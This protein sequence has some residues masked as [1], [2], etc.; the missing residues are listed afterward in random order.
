[1]IQRAMSS[2]T[3]HGEKKED[4]KITDQ[5]FLH[6]RGSRGNIL[7]ASLMSRNRRQNSGNSIAN[8]ISK[9]FHM[10]ELSAK[11]VLD[12]GC[13]KSGNLELMKRRNHTWH[14]V[15]CILDH[16]AHLYIFESEQSSHSIQICPLEHATINDCCEVNLSNPLCVELVFAPDD[17]KKMPECTLK[18]ADLKDKHDWI[19]VLRN[20]QGHI[21]HGMQSP[22]S[23]GDALSPK[24]KDVDATSPAAATTSH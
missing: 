9:M 11:E 10:Q 22:T 4:H 6:K 16:D 2:G 12:K 3:M 1:M 7:G 19:G 5:V 20:Q 8:F 23:T 15:F 18:C 13:V 24:G 17:S 21:L 14:K